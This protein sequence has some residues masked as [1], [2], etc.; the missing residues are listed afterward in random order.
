[1]DNKI[2]VVSVRLIKDA[3]IYSD[4]PCISPKDVVALL[5][6]IMCEFDRETVCIINLKSNMTVINVNFA[7]VG[8]I[9]QAMAHP[10]EIMKAAI[11]S[12]AAN[13][14]MI[15]NH[16]SGELMPSKEDVM[17]TERMNWVCELMGIPLLDHIIVG[18]DNKE[19]F[20]F[21]EKG[22]INTPDLHLSTEY[23]DIE[24]TN[25]VPEVGRA[26]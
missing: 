25:D 21:K 24:L 6:D 5:G 2:D 4:R 10:R 23:K 7:S 1:M 20:S 15:H 8:C 3:P 16:P 13:I 14:I 17:I 11:L 9:N 18:G 12:N 26:R 19:Y 22:I